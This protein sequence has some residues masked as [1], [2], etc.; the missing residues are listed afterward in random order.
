MKASAALLITMTAL[1]F[2][3][4]KRPG[5]GKQIMLPS[6]SLMSCAATHL[7]QDAK[8]GTDSIYPV[9]VVMDHFD[10]EGCPQGIVALYGKTVSEEE[11]K[12][13]LDRRYS[14]WA[15]PLAK[16]W[17]VEPEKFVIQLA[18]INDSLKE[19]GV[20]G[21]KGMKQVIYLAFPVP[22]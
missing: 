5:S 17:R 3:Q 11:I 22:K 19:E 13:A 21:E 2:C 20:T 12:T 6:S 8:A 18:T 7:W 9:Q 10:H 4:P 1:V 14:K 15:T 16:L